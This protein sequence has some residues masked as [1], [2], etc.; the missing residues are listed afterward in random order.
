MKTKSII[1][2]REL[3]LTILKWIKSG[4]NTSSIARL[5]FPNAKLPGQSLVGY[6]IKY[7][8]LGLI[9]KPSRGNYIITIDGKWFIKYLT[10]LTNER[11]I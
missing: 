10:K 8:Y 7:L 4:A 1:E 9:E 3:D 5:V 6:L 11:F 2:L